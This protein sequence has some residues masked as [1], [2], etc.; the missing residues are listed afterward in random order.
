MPGTVLGPEDSAVDRVV[1]GS[2]LSRPPFWWK[3]T[4]NKQKLNEKNTR[5]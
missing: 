1:E 2:L 4:E 3:K 5:L